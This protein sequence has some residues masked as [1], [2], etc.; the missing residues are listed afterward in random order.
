MQAASRPLPGWTSLQSVL[1]FAA[2]ALTT[3]SLCAIAGE[4][5]N[6][7]AAPMMN[8]FLNMRNSLT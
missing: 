2:Q 1:I 4:A 5:R 6:T 7:K 3:P 8:G